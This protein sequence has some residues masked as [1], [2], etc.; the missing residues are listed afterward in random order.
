[1]SSRRTTLHFTERAG[2]ND[3]ILVQFEFAVCDLTFILLSNWHFRD[4]VG[5]AITAAIGQNFI[6]FT[7]NHFNAVS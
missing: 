6:F 7:I 1:M 5:F 2:R 3:V 4:V